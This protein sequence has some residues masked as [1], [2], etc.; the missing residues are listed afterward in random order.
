MPARS[1]ATAAWAIE[2]EALGLL[3]RLDRVRPFALLETMVPAAALSPVAQAAIDRFLLEE[4]TRLRSAIGALLAWLRGPGR[5]AE[6]AEQQRRFVLIRLRFNQT[7]AHFDMFSDAITQRSESDVGVLLSGLEVAAAEALSLPGGYFDDPPMICYLDRGP[8]A[9]IRRARTRLPGG[10]PNPVSMI[11]VPRER[12]IG[13]GIASS[14]FH[15]VGHQGAA[16][17]GLV[18]SLRDV[19]NR[20]TLRAGSV[21]E[22]AAWT[23]WGRW[24]SEIVADLWAIGRVGIT[25]TLGLLGVVSLPA[26]FVFRIGVDD[27]HPTPW[28][29]VLLSCVIGD[30]LYPHA[31]WG[32]QARHWTAYYPPTGVQEETRGAIREL[33]RTMPEFVA[34]LL[35]HRPASLR[36][37]PLGEVLRTPG[38]EPE[39]LDALLNRWRS[40][41][42]MIRSA[43]PS[44][45]FAVLGQ[46][47]FNGRIGAREESE[48]LARL[49]THWALRST[50]DLTELCAQRSDDAQRR[51]LP[52]TASVPAH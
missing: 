41:R 19:I 21:P 27:P 14:L 26:Y 39:R 4:R 6:T 49:I 13:N 5:A 12:M 9:A 20:R 48:L 16:L 36:G 22:R 10:R 40:D 50:Q 23:L 45:V 44:L 8:G 42:G 34:L 52:A 3:T 43:S 15:E 37:R 28:V 29:R 46:A 17:L 24:I 11:R 33:V 30:A 31:Q 7:L 51:A 47:R 35:A 25:S 18:E 1:V 2:Q 32:R 38:L